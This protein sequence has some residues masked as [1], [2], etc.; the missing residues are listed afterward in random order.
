MARRAVN[1]EVR[2][3]DPREPLERLIKRFTKKVKK[4]KVLEIFRERSRYEKPSDK[5]RKD[6]AR[7][8]RVLDKLRKEKN[9]TQSDSK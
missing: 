2:Q 7:R 6:R 3:K 1:V 5:R 4:E 8:K 9:K